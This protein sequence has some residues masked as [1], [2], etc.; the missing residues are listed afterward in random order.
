MDGQGRKEREEGEREL[1]GGSREEGGGVEVCE[2]ETNGDR[3]DE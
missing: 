3:K 1:E 2:E